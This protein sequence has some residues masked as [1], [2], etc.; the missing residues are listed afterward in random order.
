M[1]LQ[2]ITTGDGMSAIG[3]DSVTGERGFLVKVVNGTK[4]ASVKGMLLSI[5]QTED[6]KVIPQANEYDTIGVVAEGGVAD[7][8]L[9][10]MWVNGS[11][12]Q[13][14]LKDAT[15]CA[16]GQLLIAADDDGRA[17]GIANPGTGL[18]AVD[19][20]FKEYGHIF[21]TKIAG[22]NILTLASLHFN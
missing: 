2:L 9:M 4:A 19:I 14:L 11:V 1:A 15:A 3:S 22:I 13:V 18:P 17:I 7:D 8:G 6:N 5:S 20:H 10:W 21:E 12:C 16:V